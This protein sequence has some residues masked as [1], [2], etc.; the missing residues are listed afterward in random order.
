MFS[1]RQ[2]FK[3]PSGVALVPL[4]GTKHANC[5]L[6]MKTI[7]GGMNCSLKIK[8]QHWWRKTVFNKTHT[9]SIPGGINMAP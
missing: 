3:I 6:K 1:V 7:P 8:E 9:H 4:K 2:V 5:S